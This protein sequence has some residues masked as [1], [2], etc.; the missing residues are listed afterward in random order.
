[1]YKN[2]FICFFSLLLLPISSYS[3]SQ[4]K[5]EG[6]HPTGMCTMDYNAWG[7]ASN[8]ACPDAYRYERRAGLCI[9]ELSILE[10][11]STEGTLLTGLVA[12]GGETKGIELIS[13]DGP[14]ELILEV[15][16]LENIEESNGLSF[17]VLGDVIYLPVVE[18]ES[19]PAIIVKE[20][21]LIQ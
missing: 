15:K 14:Y 8:C 16:T 21:N 2:F 18:R 1:M 6:I 10:E 5:P 7:N 11:I 19:R 4:I 3:Q 9:P 12:I 17:E 13:N 20:M